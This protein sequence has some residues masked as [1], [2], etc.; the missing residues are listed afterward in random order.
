[1]AHKFA[2]IGFTDAVKSVQQT[3][4]SR[5]AY[6][7]RE[8][9]SDINRPLGP[10]EIKFLAERDSFYIA[11]VSEIGWP[12]VQ[13]RGGP[14]GFLRVLDE[15]TLGFADFRGNRLYITTGNVATDSRI[16]LLLID[17]PNRRRLKIL[18][19]MHVIG[20]QDDAALAARLTFADYAS[21]VERVM[22]IKVEAFD[23]NCPQHIPPALPKTILRQ[24]SPLTGSVDGCRTN[25][26]HRSADIR[27]SSLRC[28]S[29][30]CTARR[31]RGP[32]R[33][34]ANCF[35][36]CGLVRQDAQVLSLPL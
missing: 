20:T 12:Y 13:F 30:L 32:S 22:L 17:S 14:A 21:A 3:M 18:G 26:R 33:P 1:M 15:Q 29:S 27:R 4:G 23:W 2:E 16:S 9:G 11:S 19:R 7:R 6:A 8:V 28:R 10:D 36:H 34:A 5:S 24:V 35:R 25:R 31:T